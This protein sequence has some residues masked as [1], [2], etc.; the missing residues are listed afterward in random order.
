MAYPGVD[1][2][3]KPSTASP[4]N[5]TNLE[6]MD[7]GIVANDAAIT[8]L[9]G[10]V[11]TVKEDLGYKKI[12]DE[13]LAMISS[14]NL[15]NVATNTVG[16]YID[17]SGNLQDNAARSTTD[18]IYL[19]AGNYWL[20][21]VHGAVPGFGYI[22][23]YN[24]SKEFQ[25]RVQLNSNT[26]TISS[27]CYVR[28][29]GSTNHL[30][31]SMLIKG[32]EAPANYIPYDNV[33]D[34]KFIPIID[35]KRILP[36]SI[37]MENVDFV[38]T[39]SNEI[40]PTKVIKGKSI[41]GNGTISDNASYA[42]SGHLKIKSSTVYSYRNIYRIVYFDEND[43]VISYSQCAERGSSYLTGTF[44]TAAGMSYAICMMAI[45]YE[46][47]WQIVEGSTLPEYEK[48]HLIIDGY[49]IYDN[50]DINGEKIIDDSISMKKLNFI[51]VKDNL[52]NQ[53]TVTEGKAISTQGVISDN[54]SY[55]LT[56]K[57]ELEPLTVYSYRNC[58]RIVY[59][60]ASDEFISCTELSGG[61]DTK[62]IGVFTTP[63]VFAY[64]I[65]M[66]PMSIRYNKEWQI[67][68]GNELTTY[69][70]QH[71][72]ID[73]Y[74]IF[75]EPDVQ[76]DPIQI[77]RDWDKIVANTT[78]E[79]L[80]SDDVA[81]IDND[82]K[83]VT[84]IY[85]K[86]DVLMQ[87]YPNYI[88]R[89]T[90]GT[91]G[92]ETNPVT[93]YRYD[94]KIK[95]EYS[96]N[97]KT[98]II[99]I[100]GVHPEYAGIYALYHALE[101]IASDPN[102]SDLKSE[103]HIIC[104]PV[105]NAYGVNTG[106]RKNHNGVD[107]ARNFE[108]GWISGTSPSSETYGGPYP[109]SETEAQYVNTIMMDNTDAVLF[110]SCHNFQSAH[111]ANGITKD[112]YCIWCA[113][114]SKYLVN[115]G[116]KVVDKMTVLWN[117]KYNWD[118]QS[119]GYSSLDSLFGSEGDQCLKYGI[120]GSTFEVGA[121]FKKYSEDSYS[122]FSTSRNTETYINLIRIALNCFDYMDKIHQYNK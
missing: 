46:N 76:E 8:A 15:Y 18:Y 49:T 64:A 60:N 96:Q 67:N 21:Y 40:N 25:S 72:E 82:D 62:Q 85:E 55:A 63:N 28:L 54:N 35:G 36:D 101:K 45:I 83:N 17:A 88:T 12:T 58:H 81:G 104:M 100:S 59:F 47:S 31:K 103:L 114:S 108:V 53:M 106:S 93:L 7:N 86:Y 4:I 75:D 33:I 66:M 91:N 116:G 97:P 2:Q 10:V 84:A 87:L 102:L 120:Q 38:K 22:A 73:G 23:Y 94:F 119:Y 71:L 65:V 39:S 57:M 79:Y 99:L 34:R 110:I 51:E 13:Q 32:T 6:I 68:K 48:Q 50:P 111:P 89:T 37:P 41:S 3:N 14:V 113:A 52:I 19:P 11:N 118:E 105:V 44:T 115:I 109:L 20:D 74:R 92:D 61:D 56:D 78:K 1:W 98:K 29:W 95:G 90:L 69:A 30:A 43:N 117:E 42:I 26:L 122:S 70:K 80:L 27:D 77:I 107:I 112:N 16:K 9:T 121:Y 5:T 24:L